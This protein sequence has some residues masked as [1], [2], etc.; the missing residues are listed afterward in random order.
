VTYRD[1]SIKLPVEKKGVGPVKKMKSVDADSSFFYRGDSRY[2]VRIKPD[3]AVTFKGDEMLRLLA[4]NFNGSPDEIAFK[5]VSPKAA[6]LKSIE[7]GE[8]TPV[9][10]ST[11]EKHSS[12]CIP[13]GHKGDI[14]F[15][16]ET[17]IALLSLSAQLLA[18]VVAS[19]DKPEKKAAKRK[20]RKSK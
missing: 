6:D 20:A 18:P 16:I 10:R 15:V 2:V 3:K 5:I 12:V 19:M 8:F 14:A 17:E 9:T 13:A 4:I 7:T 11:D 1:D